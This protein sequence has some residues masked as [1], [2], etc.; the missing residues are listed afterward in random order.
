MLF[1]SSDGRCGSSW[2]PGDSDQASIRDDYRST[3]AIGASPGEESVI[4][5]N[6]QGK[7]SSNWGGG[8]KSWGNS[9]CGG[10]AKALDHLGRSCI[11][12]ITGL[13]G[14]DSTSAASESG[15]NSTRCNSTNAGG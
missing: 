2:K 9:D 8:A 7:A 6:L 4:V 14:G 3:C 12:C 1:R 5:T 11:T 15:E 13:I 10:D